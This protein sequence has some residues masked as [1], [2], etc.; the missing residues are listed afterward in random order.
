MGRAS[1]SM[2]APIKAIH[3]SWLGPELIVCCLAY[4]SSTGVFLLLKI[5]ISSFAPRGLIARQ[6]IVSVSPRFL[7]I[8][9][10]IIIYLFLFFHEDSLTSVTMRTDQLTVVNRC[11]NWL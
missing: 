7:F 6:F 4:R 1:D 8:L 11:R 10:V 2:M 5:S 3:F 9:V